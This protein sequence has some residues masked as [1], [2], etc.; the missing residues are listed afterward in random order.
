[1][2]MAFDG[3][4]KNLRVLPLKES[5]RVAKIAAAWNTFLNDIKTK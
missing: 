5:D 1:M 3:L 4:D 2:E